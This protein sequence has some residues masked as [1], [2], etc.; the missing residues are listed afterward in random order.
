MP[1]CGVCV[2]VCLS[3]T[4]VSCVKTNK[5]I[6]KNFSLSGSHTIIVFP[7]QTGC[8]YSDGKPH[9]GGVEWRWSRQKRDSGRIFGFATCRSTVL[10]TVRVAKYDKQSCDKRRQASST[11]R[12]VRRPLFAQEDDEVFVTGSTLYAGDEGSST[13]LVIVTVFCCRR[14]S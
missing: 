4:F 2:S 7:D 12:G 3:G 14:I 10:S 5:H 11:R 6:I 1:L 9:N 8:Q 13:P